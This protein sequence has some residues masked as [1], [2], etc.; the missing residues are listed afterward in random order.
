MELVSGFC[1]RCET[2]AVDMVISRLVIE[3]DR[4]DG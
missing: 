4:N 2:G 1:G 3:E